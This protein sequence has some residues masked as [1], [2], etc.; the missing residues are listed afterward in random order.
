[1]LVGNSVVPSSILDSYFEFL[2]RTLIGLSFDILNTICE[3][4]S[5][6]LNGF[7]IGNSQYLCSNTEL[8]LTRVFFFKHFNIFRR[9]TK[10]VLNHK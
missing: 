2:C 7:N 3:V 8:D 1:M 5:I 9:E 6:T 4:I 10:F